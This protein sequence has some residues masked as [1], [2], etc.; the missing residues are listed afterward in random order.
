[1]ESRIWRNTATGCAPG[2]QATLDVEARRAR[3]ARLRRTLGV[4]RH[5]LQRLPVDQAL[6]EGVA[7]DRRRVGQR[8]E[9]CARFRERCPGRLVPE[10]QVV[11]FPELAGL[12]GAHRHFGG[13]G[14]VR[15]DHRERIVDE[16]PAHLAGRDVL[17][18][19]LGKGVER[20]APAVRALEVRH[21][22]DRDRRRRGTA[23]T[24]G[25]RW[26]S[27]RRQRRCHAS[28]SAG[29]QR[30]RR[31]SVIGI[32]FRFSNGGGGGRCQATASCCRPARGRSSTTRHSDRAHPTSGRRS[33]SDPS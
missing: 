25:E 5:L 2:Q 10:E 21:L 23:G 29:Q 12:R 26:R 14:G 20:E 9:E 8:Q 28:R 1:M 6:P 24:R 19:E 3:R 13:R 22:V 16:Y 33:T 31:R 30:A 27:L 11:H 7:R 17:A 15:M 32:A 18:V 4:T